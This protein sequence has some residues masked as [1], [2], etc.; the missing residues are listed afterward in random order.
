MHNVKPGQIMLLLIVLAVGVPWLNGIGLSELAMPVA[1][2]GGVACFAIPS[3]YKYIKENTNFLDGAPLWTFLLAPPAELD[4]HF[5][6]QAMEREEYQEKRV[7]TVESTII[8]EE[9]A[10]APTERLDPIIKSR[11][12]EEEEKFDWDGDAEEIALP[13][14]PRVGNGSFT[15]SDVLASGFRPSLNEIYLGRRMDGTDIIVKAKDLCHVA[16]AGNTGGG[17]SSLMRLIMAQLCYIR[18][19]VLLLNPHYM[20]L[21]RS[22]DPPEDWTPFTPY[23]ERD[24][25]EC[26][27]YDQIRSYLDYVTNTL[28]PKRIERARVG[29]HLGKPFFVVIDELPAIAKKIKESPEWMGE[30]LREGR[31]YGIFLVVASQDFLVK[32]TGMDGG[33][34]R[35]CLRTALYVGGDTTTAKELLNI[36]PADI[37]EN[38]LGKG[39]IM[40]RCAAT[41]DAVMARVPYVDNQSLCD[42]LGPSTFN[43][44][45]LDDEDA[46]L[47]LHA[48]ASRASA[49]HGDAATI[50]RQNAAETAQMDEIEPKTNAPITR[51]TEPVRALVEPTQAASRPRY[52]LMSDVQAAAFLGAYKTRPNM[53][54]SLKT[55]GCS[56]VYREHAR[57]LLVENGLR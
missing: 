53:D 34:V 5:V 39:T 17:K 26:A 14:M 20:L 9:T 44:N 35:K 32:T 18:A 51:D 10:N 54:Y 43:F 21:D 16:L 49:Q 15:F 41:K 30:L 47:T 28:L 33:A 4:E 11:R 42:L 22:N 38:D 2:I 24:P 12:N 31:K 25:I 57:Q 50:T 8:D 23:L 45:A 3:G 52:K 13:T 36:V 37:P 1:V 29:Q 7:T 46:S 6:T 27:T 56:T 55:A 40:I 48:P 19:H